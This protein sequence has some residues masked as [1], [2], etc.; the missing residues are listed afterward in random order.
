MLVTLEDATNPVALLEDGA[1]RQGVA[2]SIGWFYVQTL[3]DEDQGGE[4]A[5]GE[6]PAA[7]SPLARR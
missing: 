7:A 1:D 5:M 6:G 3:M 2:D 4:A